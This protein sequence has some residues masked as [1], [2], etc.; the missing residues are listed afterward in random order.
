MTIL[1]TALRHFILRPL[2]EI[3]IRLDRSLPRTGQRPEHRRRQGGAVGKKREPGKQ[4]LARGSCARER[5]R[6]LAQTWTASIDVTDRIHHRASVRDTLRQ[7]S[8]ETLRRL[9]L[10]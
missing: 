6:I 2:S 10:R 1:A 4:I 3:L 7:Q 8:P 5:L 9:L